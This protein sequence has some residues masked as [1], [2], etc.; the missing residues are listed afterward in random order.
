MKRTMIKTCVAAVASITL[1]FAF[2]SCDSL[3]DELSSEQLKDQVAGIGSVSAESTV[4]YY[5]ESKDKSVKGS[6]ER[7]LTLNLSQIANADKASVKYALEYTIGDIVYKS[8]GSSVGQL[9]DSKTKYYV[10]LSPAINL[11]DGTGSPSSSVISLS[12][13]VSGLTNA[14][15]N[16][17]DGRSFPTFSK[18]IK[19]EPLY[20]AEIEPF[21]TKSAPA[22]T[23]FEIPLNGKITA[24][25]EA[26][27]ATK[28]DGDDDIPEGAEFTASVSDDG[29]KI[30]LTSSE[31]L[32]DRNFT[33]DF[34]FTGI[35][36]VGGKEKYDYTVSLSF[37]AAEVHAVT[38]EITFESEAVDVMTA[39]KFATFGTIQK[40]TATFSGDFTGVSDKWYAGLQSEEG[41]SGNW[42]DFTWSS[43]DGNIGN[44][45]CTLTSALI[46]AA[47]AEGGKLQIKSNAVSGTLV[48]TI[49]ASSK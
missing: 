33:A 5:N 39:E 15:G 28:T 14:S 36:P 35:K 27:T 46:S 24:I 30:I 3:Q 18:K 17:Y 31:E 47:T 48:L 34:T 19:F 45:T 13:T 29:T 7:W 23:T 41:N 25:D 22:G 37:N 1:L 2:A 6:D 40:I 8:E 38:K 4:F 12:V 32:T 20:N 11:I 10:D 21:S 49:S 9:S 16:D 42:N 44:Y 26:V 43:G